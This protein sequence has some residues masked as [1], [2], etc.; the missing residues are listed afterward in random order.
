MALQNPQR[1]FRRLCLT[2]NA[3]RRV[4]EAKVPLPLPPEMVHPKAIDRLLT[5]DS[6]HQGFYAEVD[7]LPSPTLKTLNVSGTVVILDQVT[8]PHNVG[9]IARARRLMSRR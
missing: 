2:E 6:V 4:E 9:A 8:D 5:P 7:P 3:L 1:R